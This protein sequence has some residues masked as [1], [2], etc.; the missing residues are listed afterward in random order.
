MLSLLEG[1]RDRATVLGGN[2]V[3][4]ADGVPSLLEFLGREGNAVLL[5][6][7]LAP[8]FPKCTM[9]PG[10]SYTQNCYRNRGPRA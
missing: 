10:H 6:F 5:Y 9:S 7:C 4:I 1:V 3:K 8:L 2:K